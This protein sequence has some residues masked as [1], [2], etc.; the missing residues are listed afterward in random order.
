[1]HISTAYVNTKLYKV[2]EKLYPAPIDRH[3]FL[4][5]IEGMDDATLE[6]QTS[7]ILRGHANPYTFTKHLAEHEITRMPAAIIRPSM[8]KFPYAYSIRYCITHCNLSPFTM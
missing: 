3:D 8:S 5:L 7:E 4:K 6:A 2:D 1:M